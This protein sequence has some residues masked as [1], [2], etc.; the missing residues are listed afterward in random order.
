MTIRSGALPLAVDTVGMAARFDGRTG[1]SSTQ[2]H[3]HE[4]R[5]APVSRK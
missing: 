1:G 3:L 2:E 5:I 4:P